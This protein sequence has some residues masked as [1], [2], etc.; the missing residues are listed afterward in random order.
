MGVYGRVRRRIVNATTGEIAFDSG[1]SNNLILDAFFTTITS[2]PSTGTGPIADVLTGGAIRAGT[3]VANPV[4]K[5]STPTTLSQTLTTVTASSGFFAAGDVGQLLVFGGSGVGTN[6]CYITAFTSSTQVTVNISQTVASVVG[7]V[8]YVS[9]AWALSGTITQ[10]NSIVTGAG[11]CGTVWTAG[12][13]THTMTWQSAVLATATT[14]LQL[15]YVNHGGVVIANFQIPGAGDTVPIN[16]FYQVTW[17]FALALTPNAPSA[18]G[19]IG[20]GINTAGNLMVERQSCISSISTSGL[21]TV[22]FLSLDGNGAAQGFPAMTTGAYTQNTT[23][24]AST[25]PTVTT[26]SYQTGWTNSTSWA[27]SIGTAQATPGNATGTYTYALNTTGTGATITGIGANVTS[28]SAGLGMDVLLTTP[29]T[30]P[31][32]GTFTFVMVFTFTI[33][34]VIT[35]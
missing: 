10:V 34:R 18:V 33:T 31:G 7:T 14:Y 4:R 2:A 24:N 21:P 26:F 32:S 22:G 25:S 17:S 13:P 8:W 30:S 15:A 5:D 29:F 35:N 28:A 3:G 9:S 27:A 6:A 19:N 23:P 1:F 20:T 12:N 11:N 16:F